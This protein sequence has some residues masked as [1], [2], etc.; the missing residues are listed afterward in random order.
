[1]PRPGRVC[2][3]ASSALTDD[4]MQRTLQWVALAKDWTMRPRKAIRF[5]HL[6]GGID[7]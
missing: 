3:A 4:K 7:M 5:S 2:V 6:A 1:M